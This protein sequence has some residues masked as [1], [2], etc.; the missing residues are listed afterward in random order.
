M[1][2]LDTFGIV[3]ITLVL[4]AGCPGDSTTASP[5]DQRVKSVCNSAIK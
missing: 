3:V 4:A 1:V 2:Q 5:F